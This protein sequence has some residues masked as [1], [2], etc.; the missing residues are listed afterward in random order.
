M[1]AAASPSSRASPASARRRWRNSSWSGALPARPRP[2]SRAGAAWRAS[3]VARRTCPSWRRSSR[4]CGG[5]ESARVQRVVRVFAPTW[6]SQFP[7]LAGGQEEEAAQRREAASL[8]SACWAPAAT[9]SCPAWASSIR[10]IP[11]HRAVVVH[12]HV[13]AGAS[14]G[15][16]L[17]RHAL[18][19]GSVSGDAPPAHGGLALSVQRTEGDGGSQRAVPAFAAQAARMRGPL[20]VMATVC[21]TCTDGLPS[22]VA[23]D[24]PSSSATTSSPPSVNIGS[25]AITR[26]S[27]SRMPRPAWP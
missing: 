26:P 1:A 16:R 13:P 4:C 6:C 18:R 12:A 25:M 17:L 5:P 27:R 11:R 21:S 19:A 2:W 7:A 14:P 10:P 15:S 23:I 9:R 3:A 24:Q 22:A 8:R 20:R